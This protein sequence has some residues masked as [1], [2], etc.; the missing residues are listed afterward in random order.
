MGFPHLL[1]VAGGSG[2]LPPGSVEPSKVVEVGLVEKG[3]GVEPVAG[4]AGHGTFGSAPGPQVAGAPTVRIQLGESASVVRRCLRTAGLVGVIVGMLLVPRAGLT[5]VETLTDDDLCNLTPS[6]G[7]WMVDLWSASNELSVLG[8]TAFEVEVEGAQA[9]CANRWPYFDGTSISVGVFAVASEAQAI[10]A[11]DSLRS[12]AEAIV[13]VRDFAV[14]SLGDEAWIADF[15][16]QQLAFTRVGRF[17]V[18]GYS[19][20]AYEYSRDDY[21]QLLIERMGT[22]IANLGTSGLGG[23]GPGPAAPADPER[24]DTSGVSCVCDGIPDSLPTALVGTATVAG[25]AAVGVAVGRPGRR[26]P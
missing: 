2:P 4:V 8:L 25:I 13:P 12:Q 14:S 7:S 18:G 9:G 21:D 24:G 26:R 15:T 17:L 20:E 22:I 10:Q 16:Y 1:T 3:G 6:D 19:D 23:A 5:Q 11:N